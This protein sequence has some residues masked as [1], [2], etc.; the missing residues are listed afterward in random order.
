MQTGTSCEGMVAAVAFE[1]VIVGRFMAVGL[2][3]TYGGM[4]GGLSDLFQRAADDLATE[5]AADLGF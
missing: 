3:V 5:R 2:F 1:S 4:Y